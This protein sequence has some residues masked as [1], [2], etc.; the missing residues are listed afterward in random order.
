[1]SPTLFTIERP[2]AGQLSTMARPRGR[3]WL[4][5]DLRSLAA[6][7]VSVLVSLLEHGEAARLGL[8]GEAAA[9]ARA[10][11][12]FLQ[13]PTPDF[14]VPEREEA[15]AVA[16]TLMCRLAAGDRCVVH[17]RAGVGRSSTLAAVVLVLE[18]LTPAEAWDRISAARGRPVPETDAQRE[19]VTS[20][21]GPARP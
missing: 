1:M 14:S 20:V 13:L 15:L 12:D 8:A 18:G 9:A 21:A 10:G 5:R 7:R 6:A 16:G 3:W 11:I 19:L 4:G 2:G 17:C